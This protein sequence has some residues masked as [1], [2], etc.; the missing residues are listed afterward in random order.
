MINTIALLPM[1]RHS[2]RVP[3]KNFKEFCGKPLFHWVLETLIDIPKIDKI[4]INTDAIDILQKHQITNNAKIILRDRPKNLCGDEVSMNKII[5]DDIDH[6]DAT[7]YI[8][9][10]TTNPLISKE[11]IES[12]L[13]YYL[14]K[15]EGGENDSLFT[16]NK[17]QTRFYTENATPINHDP[18]NLIPTQD[19]TPWFEENSNLYIFSKS[20]F[21]KTDAR[22]GAKPVLFT[23]PLKESIDIDTL[24]EWELGEALTQI[25]KS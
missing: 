17:V 25:L 15:C 14:S 3:G 10:H 12:A 6:V 4:I 9:T 18:N 24:E 5:K 19:L 1:K 8:M 21:L 16:A 11:T 7:R 2:S 13:D 20:S 23:T 22:I